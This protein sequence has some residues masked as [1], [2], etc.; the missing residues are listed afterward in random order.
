[1]IPECEHLNELM[2][3]CVIFE[4]VVSNYPLNKVIEIK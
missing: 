4:S 2:S 1:M 3:E